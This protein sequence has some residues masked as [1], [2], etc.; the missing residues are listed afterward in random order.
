MAGDPADVGH[1]GKD[2]A[3][4]VVENI[5]VGERGLQQVSRRGVGHAFGAAGAARGVEEKER[6]LTVHVFDGA[7]GA[8]AVHGLTQPDVAL[9]IEGNLV[10]GSP[11]HEHRA[12]RGAG[13]DSL[14]DGALERDGFPAT[15]ALVGGDH[16]RAA[17]VVD[18]I[19]QAL[20]RESREHDIVYG[21]DARTGQHR[22]HRLGDHRHIDGNAVAFAC[23][24]VTKDVGQPADLAL[25]FA[26]GDLDA[27]SR[28]VRLPN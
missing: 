17:R 26:V 25:Q 1:A 8:F 24:V 15:H 13:H 28:R 2:I 4:V 27:F 5:A 20:G 10:A 3:V 7:I 16:G 12:H 18:T 22:V 6:V 11:G 23:A 9:G 19:A 21:A 14:V